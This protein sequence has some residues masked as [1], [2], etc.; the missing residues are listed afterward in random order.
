MPKVKLVIEITGEADGMYPIGNLTECLY[1]LI[2]WLEP[3]DKNAKDIPEMLPLSKTVR[4]IGTELV[5]S[6]T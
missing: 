1:Q 3:R 6:I 2:D 5:L 4:D